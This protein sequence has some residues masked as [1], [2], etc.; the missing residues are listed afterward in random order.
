[1][2]LAKAKLALHRQS[3][4]FVEPKLVVDL[5][6]VCESLDVLHMYSIL[7]YRTARR[8]PNGNLVLDKV[9]FLAFPKNMPLQL[10]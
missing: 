10:V 1:M 6:D 4:S 8:F 3:N 9:N 2:F 7:A 5:C